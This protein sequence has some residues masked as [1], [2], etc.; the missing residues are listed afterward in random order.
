MSAQ[1]L[2]MSNDI[3]NVFSIEVAGKLKLTHIF[4]PQ[5]SP[6]DSSGD[7]S[8]TVPDRPTATGAAGQP[9]STEQP[10]NQETK[11]KKKRKKKAKAV[12]TEEEEGGKKAGGEDD[13]LEFPGTGSD[14][15]EQNA[16]TGTVEGSSPPVEEKKK[17]KK[18]PKEKA[19]GKEP[20]EPKTPK[21]PKT[22]K[23]PK[24]KKT[25][26]TTPKAKTPKK[27]R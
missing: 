6:T 3:S 1:L 11:P 24:E 10:S 12:D 22:P 15:G 4:L 16:G 18:K 23:E 5:H 9:I 20:K 17:R 25:K 8:M 19:E 27:T 13:K 7:A 21:T 14:A 2:F 26:S